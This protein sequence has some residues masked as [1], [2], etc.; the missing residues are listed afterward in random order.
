MNHI[1][2]TYLQY[3]YDAATFH[4][5]SAAARENFVS[6]SAISQGI[7]K[8]E[9]ALKSQLTTHQKQKFILTEEGEIVFKEAKNLFSAA[10][11]L[12]ERLSALKGEISGEVKFACTNSLAQFYLPTAYLNMK[13]KFPLVDLK[14]HRGG[15]NYIHD[16]LRK[17]KVNFA[18]VLDAPEFENYERISI[19]QGDFRLYKKKNLKNTTGI[20]V[21]HLENSEVIE[22]R[23]RHKE[24]YKKDIDILDTLSGWALVLTFVQLGHGT[25]YLPEF[26]ARDKKELKEVKLDITPIR[27]SIC[28]IKPKGSLLT[29][30]ESAFLD[31]LRQM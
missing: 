28:M 12:K 24:R 30:A 9:I 18:L 31:I 14:F 7:S 13:N 2:L 4:S 25:G 1:N 27:Y 5:I 21:D 16:S 19:S 22:F 23:E 26:I 3:F 17:E 8:L 11:K 6:Q 20:L 29:R 15:L 10:A